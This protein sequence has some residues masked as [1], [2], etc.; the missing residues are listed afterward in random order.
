ML[1]EFK[2][3]VVPKVGEEIELRQFEE[4]HAEELFAL[5]EQ[6]RRRLYWLPASHS[7]EDTRKFIRHWLEKSAESKGFKA[8]IWCGGALAGAVG[9]NNIDWQ[10]KSVSL[11]YWLAAPFEGRGF[12]TQSCRVLIDHAFGGLGLNRVEIRCAAGNRRSRAIPE[13]LGFTM[14]GVLRQAEWVGGRKD[15]QVVYGLLAGEWE[16]GR[17]S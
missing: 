15:D 11:G 9:F 3:R 7:L 8:G 16:A 6:N 1:L 12:V 13:R 17:K 10:N 4:R 14:E 5:I 2:R